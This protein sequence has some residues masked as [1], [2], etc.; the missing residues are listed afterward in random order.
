M[1]ISWVGYSILGGPLITI[2]LGAAHMI[3]KEL[4]AYTKYEWLKYVIIIPP[5][6]IIVGIIIAISI[7]LGGLYLSFKDYFNN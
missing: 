2:N 6:A 7:C 3:K 4:L 5:I 1:D